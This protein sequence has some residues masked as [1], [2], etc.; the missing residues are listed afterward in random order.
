MIKI[1]KNKFIVKILENHS[2]KVA[3]YHCKNKRFQ[4]LIEGLFEEN[5]RKE[6]MANDVDDKMFIQPHFFTAENIKLSTAR[7]VTVFNNVL[8]KEKSEAYQ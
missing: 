3:E 5:T 7:D 8:V 6:R 4:K 1:R 2:K